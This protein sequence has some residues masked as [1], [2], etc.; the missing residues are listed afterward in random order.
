MCLIVRAPELLLSGLLVA[1]L[2]RCPWHAESR[3]IFWLAISIKVRQNVS[4]PGISQNVILMGN[5][6]MDGETPIM[7]F[8]WGDEEKKKTRKRTGGK[9]AS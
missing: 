9:R 3:K 5:G 6:R 7:L 1:D 2:L 8:L 4:Y